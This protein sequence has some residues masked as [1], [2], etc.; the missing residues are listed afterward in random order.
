MSLPVWVNGA[1]VE[2]NGIFSIFEFSWWALK[3]WLNSAKTRVTLTDRRVHA[4]WLVFGKSLNRH[5]RGY[6][7]VPLP[8]RNRPSGLV[9]RKTSARCFLHSSERYLTP[10]K[11]QDRDMQLHQ[12]KKMPMNSYTKEST[13]TCSTVRCCVIYVYLVNVITVFLNVAP[14][15]YGFRNHLPFLWS[16][17]KKAHKSRLSCSCETRT[18]SD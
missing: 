10:T 5:L 13:V 18:H 4:D 7:P 15:P 16:S 11:V 9:Y 6:I 1:L 14:F 2:L 12:T 17:L 3:L 8:E